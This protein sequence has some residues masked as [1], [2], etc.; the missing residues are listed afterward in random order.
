[1]D[2]LHFE[3]NHFEFFFLFKNV[4]LMV[5]VYSAQGEAIMGEVSDC[6]T[7]VMIIIVVVLLC[8]S[9]LASAPLL[10]DCKRL[11]TEG[12][13]IKPRPSSRWKGER[14]TGRRLLSGMC[15]SPNWGE[16]MQDRRRRAPTAAASLRLPAALSKQ[17]G[18]R[19]GPRLASPFRN[20]PGA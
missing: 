18:K 11:R 3:Q 16:E 19:R 20:A 10:Y 7:M 2:D 8:L 1:M 9:F 5:L 13:R 4:N 12:K 15:R 14:A 6:F 17:G